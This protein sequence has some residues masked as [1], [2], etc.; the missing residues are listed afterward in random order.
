MKTP[1]ER[2]G[3]ARP[4]IPPDAE[5]RPADGP[6]DRSGA[7]SAVADLP[8]ADGESAADLSTRQK[9]LLSK[10]AYRARRSADDAF[11]EKE[12]ERVKEWRLKNPDKTRAQK[13]AARSANYHR[14]F[15]AIDSE[16]QN[17]PGDDILYDGVRY[18][19]HDTYLWGVAADDDRPPL[20][21]SA[22]ETHG[23][24]KRPLDAIQ[25]LDWLLGLPEQFGPAVFVM[26]S[27]GYDITQILKHLPYEK[28]W[29]T[30]KRETCPDKDGNK[31]PIGH[32][33]VFWKNY[34]IS[35]IKGKSFDSWRL[36]D[37]DRPYIGGKINRSRISEFM[38]SSDFSSRHL[39]RSQRAWSRAG[40]RP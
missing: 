17:Y 31:R 23:L 27:F 11:R 28:A 19:K 15:V 10:A 35:Y 13:Q 1:H 4:A 22:A 8:S 14:P 30:E 33:P 5:V 7:S 34:A 16:G 24:D 18:P 39:A 29:Q 36:A 38:T 40:A 25:I 12:R 9:R 2:R 26:F 20:W 32:A 3:G 37:P 6:D 21:L